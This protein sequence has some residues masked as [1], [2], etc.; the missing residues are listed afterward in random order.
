M[1]EL[2]GT[3][4]ALRLLPHAGE[5]ENPTPVSRLPPPPWPAQSAPQ[6]PSPWK[7]RV[8]QTLPSPGRASKSSILPA[9]SWPASSPASSLPPPWSLSLG[10]PPFSFCKSSHSLSCPQALNRLFPLGCGEGALH[11]LFLA[12]SCS[13]CLSP[14][15]CH[16]LPEAFLYLPGALRFTSY[17]MRIFSNAHSSFLVRGRY[18]SPCPPRC[19]SVRSREGAGRSDVH[20]TLQCQG[21]GR[22]PARWGGEVRQGPHCAGSVVWNTP[23]PRRTAEDS[24]KMWLPPSESDRC[25]K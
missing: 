14:C 11:P 12:D 18:L 20:S 5:P 6:S 25:T 15:K 21:K 3:Q 24:G 22:G 2:R 19:C 10:W 17:R 1:L 23:L 8:I 9:A 16:R 4:T 7:S 13:S